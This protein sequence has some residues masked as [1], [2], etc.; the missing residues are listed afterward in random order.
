MG[1]TEPFVL[2]TRCRKGQKLACIF[3]ASVK[4]QRPLL[5]YHTKHCVPYKRTH[6]RAHEHS[7]AQLKVL[8]EKEELEQR[9][10]KM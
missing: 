8:A 6:T 2:P 7:A 10:D 3:L 1:Q 5:F 4:F 9:G